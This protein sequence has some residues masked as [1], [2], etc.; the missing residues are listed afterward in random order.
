MSGV[1]SQCQHDR[2]RHDRQDHCLR[3]AASNIANRL[4][5]Q[6][7][8]LHPD[9]PVRLHRHRRRSAGRQ[10][11]R[12]H[13]GA[14][15]CHDH[16]GIACRGGYR[17]VRHDH[18]T[19]WHDLYRRYFPGHPARLS[20]VCAGANDQR[21]FHRLEWWI[22]GNRGG[23]M[24][25]ITPVQNT[26]N[27]RY[28]N[29]LRITTPSA[30]YRFATTPSALTIPAVDASPF[31]GLGAACIGWLGTARHQIDRSRNNGNAGR[32]RYINARASLGR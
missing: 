23:A 19:G 7:R 9:R 12:K 15:D 28:A 29:F 30:T 1:Q 32:H 2:N 11:D 8:R 5:C 25:V 6:N 21:F 14:S 22:P 18:R 17:A 13:P 3:Y 10:R 16:R 31:S 4:R 24:N 26:N 20:N 27:I